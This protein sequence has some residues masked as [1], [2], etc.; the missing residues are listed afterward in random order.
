MIA[1]NLR[2]CLGCCCCLLACVAASA[3]AVPAHRVVMTGAM[4]LIRQTG[5]APADENG[6]DAL[7]AAGVALRASKRFAAAQGAEATLAAKR[8]ALEDRPVIRALALLRQ[9]LAKPVFLPRDAAPITDRFPRMAEFR[10]LARLLAM[11][12]YVMFAE[13][14]VADAI[15]SARLG[16]RLAQAVQT[17]TLIT[18]MVGLAISSLTLHT[19]GDHL[20]QFS[21]RDCELLYQACQEWLRQPDLYPRVLEAERDF[22]RRSLPDTLADRKAAEQ[23]LDQMF[24]RML[25]EWKKPAW[26]RS[27]V[28]PRDNNGPGGILISQAVAPLTQVSHSYTREQAQMRLLAC[29]AAVRRFRWEHDRLP[30]GLVELNLGDRAI[31]P[32]TGQPLKY[33]LRGKR[34]ELTSAGPPA[35][36]GDRQA[37]DG[38]RPVS[39]V[40]AE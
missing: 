34:Y 10:G 31:D 20:D 12:Q 28:E 39:V 30:S 13:G 17:D 22:V 26:Q 24:I 4:S 21:S 16:M 36:A 32:F 3:E 37:V 27:P 9:G 40:P 8:A 35:D 29:H 23:Q 25:T 1:F 6:Y 33:T 15:G 19:L 18:G 14:R 11:Q 38:R 7:V 5:Q 2:R